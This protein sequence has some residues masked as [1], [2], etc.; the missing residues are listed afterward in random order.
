MENQIFIAIVVAAVT[1]FVST[2]TTVVAL[3]VHIMYLRESIKNLHGD[4]GRVDQS[5][6][7]AHKRIDKIESE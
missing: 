7:R 1:G 6:I 3:R 5:V 2:F 4:I